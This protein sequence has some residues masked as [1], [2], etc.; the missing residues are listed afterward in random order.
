MTSKV[1]VM[2]FALHRKTSDMT[3]E[4]ASGEAM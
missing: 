1:S 3:E 4:Q 2:Y